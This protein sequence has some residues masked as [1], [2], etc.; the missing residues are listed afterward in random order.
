MIS[1]FKSLRWRLFI[2]IV[3]VGVLPGVIITAC[4][5]HFYEKRTLNNDVVSITS[6]AQLFNNQIITSG[7]LSDPGDTSINT[8]FAALGNIYSG[9]IMVID[10]SFRVIKDT[11]NLYEGRIM[12]WENVITTM[13]G[14]RSTVFDEKSRT[15]IV[16]VPITASD[17][18]EVQGVLMITRSLEYLESNTSF[19]KDM[20]VYA[21]LVVVILSV[22]AGL[23]FSM[24]IVKPFKKLSDTLYMPE[25]DTVLNI[26]PVEDYNETMEISERL[27]QII[28]RMNE[29]D[30]SRREFVSNVSHELKT[31]LTSMKVL[32]DSINSMGEAPAELYREFMGDITDEID[33][34]TKIIND[35]L[36]LVKM[37]KSHAELNISSINLNDLTEAILKRLR[38]IAQDQEVELVLESFRPVT[39]EGDE[40]KLSLAITNLIENGIKYN[41]PGGFVRL[42]LNSDHQYAYIRVEDSGMGIP[43]D[44][45]ARI[46]ERFYRVDKSHSREI[47]GTGLGLAITKSVIDMHKGEIHVDSEVGEG[48]TF[49]VRIPINYIK[50]SV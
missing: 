50:E 40:V 34:E 1:F 5:F 12:V 38:P 21:M 19:F 48:T 6:Q 3:W 27:G 29:I 45:L 42:S 11:Y 43:Q 35:L 47:G 10:G 24:R 16:T 46:F 14:K 22:T 32:A 8:Q 9:R 4:F 49:D 26:E 15:L 18:D 13:Q 31:P 23:V 41:N 44:S 39:I 20:S 2:L 30:D 17:S 28:S 25:S 33:R 36:S 37:D 7:Y